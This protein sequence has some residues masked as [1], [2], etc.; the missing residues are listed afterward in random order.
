MTIGK[1]K[2]GGGRRSTRGVGG[3]ISTASSPPF[4]LYASTIESERG[5]NRLSMRRSEGERGG[6]RE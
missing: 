6:V 1:G 2:R 5:L 4:A 3:E